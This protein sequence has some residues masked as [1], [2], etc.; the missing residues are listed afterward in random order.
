MCGCCEIFSPIMLH[1]RT[2]KKRVFELKGMDAGNPKFP[3]QIMVCNNSTLGKG[4][5]L[6][7]SMTINLEKEHTW[8]SWTESSSHLIK[9][10][11]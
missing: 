1:I 9:P 3:K 2:L 10:G 8:S 11:L 5:L 4:R 6:E 7:T